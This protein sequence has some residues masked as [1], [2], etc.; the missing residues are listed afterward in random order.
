M[1]RKRIVAGSLAALATLATP[2]LAEDSK[3]IAPKVFVITMFGDEAKPW[4]ANENLTDVV[5]VPGLS[6]EY[7]E[8]HCGTEGLCHMTTAMGFANAASSVSA[9]VYSGRFDLSQTYFLIAGIAGVDPDDGT[10]GSAHWAR[11]AVD[12]GLRHDIDARQIPAGWSSGALALGAKAPGEK[13]TWGSKTELYELNEGLLQRAYALSKD[14]ELLDGDEAKSYRANYGKGPGSAAP[15]VSICDTLSSDT[16]WH[17]KRLADAMAELVKAATDGKGNY[18]TTQ[19]ED[20]A[21]LTALQRGDMAG[22]LRFDRVALLRTASNFDR[23]PEGGDAFQS[24]KARSGGFPLATENAYRVGHALTSDILA[25][26]D[27][28][29]AGVPAQ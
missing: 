29:S 27:R 19:M 13:A 18:C 25:N 11:Y 21:T 15:V 8:V 7:P 14:V 16:Y 5:K 20:N 9:M 28:W 26:W 3:P 4:L 22:L 17:G 1:K 6:A 24:L 12:G 2:A 23:E 10:L